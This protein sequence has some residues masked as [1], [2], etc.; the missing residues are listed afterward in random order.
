MQSFRFMDR[1]LLWSSYSLSSIVG[2]RSSAGKVA[3]SQW[4]LKSKDSTQSAMRRAA[5]ICGGA[6]IPR[7][8]QQRAWCSTDDRPILWV[9][10]VVQVHSLTC[11]DPG[12]EF[13]IA[14]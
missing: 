5:P 13:K 11:S 14:T 4:E 8:S 1:S 2:C 3:R 7:T 12:Q 6:H 10:P 9:R